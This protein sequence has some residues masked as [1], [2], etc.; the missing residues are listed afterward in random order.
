MPVRRPPKRSDELCRRPQVR[1][2][3]LDVFAQVQEGFTDQNERSDG[4]MD[5]WDLYDCKLTDKQFYNGQSQIFLPYVR[6]AVNARKTRFCN[7]IFPQSGR[8]VDVFT[9]DEYLPDATIALLETYVRRSR[10]KTEVMPAL[11]KNGDIEGQY[12]VYVS[13]VEERRQVTRREMT[14]SVTVGEIELPELG[15]HAE[16][17][18]TTEVLGRPQVDVIHDADFLVL[19]VTANSIRDA[20]AQGGSVTVIRRWTKGRIESAI[21][22]G[23]IDE[24]QG[25]QLLAAMQKAAR[26]GNRNTGARLA[27]A[28]G[29]RENGEFALIYET[30]TN[31]RVDGRSYLCVGLYGGDSNVL[32]CKRCPYWCDLPPIISAPVEK[33]ADV[34]KG[35]AP[36]DAVATLQVFAN[37]TINE[38]ADTAHFSAMPIVMTDPEKN[39]KTS[40]M[41]LGLAA[42]WETSPQDTQFAQFPE[43]WVSAMQRAQ[44]IQGQIFQ[45]LGVNPS[46]M[47]QSSGGE[48]KR[49]QAEIANEQQVDILTTADAV[50]VLEEGILTPLIQR[51][52]E[53]DHQFR[54][55]KAVVATY[56]PMGYRATM[57]EVE[58]IQLNKRFE[59]VWLGVEAARNAAQLQQQIAGMNVLK[60]I[61]PQMYPGYRLNLQP[62][63]ENM[64]LSMFG[65]RL[66][67][68]VFERV[69]DVTVDPAIENQMLANAFIVETHPPDDDEAHL[70]EHM[71]AL[72]A[73]G[74]V[75]AHGTFRDHIAKHQ[76]QMQM[77]A[78]AQAMSMA[79]EQQGMPGS[80]GA[81]GMPGA[82]GTPRPGG[83]V[84]GPRLMKGPAGMIHPD[85]MTAAGAV[86]MPRNM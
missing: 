55:D 36:V 28:A 80:P 34:F 14:P 24:E 77:K 35:K 44:A 38:G 45:T 17:R 8:Y 67:P 62:A 26:D 33:Q 50:G 20:L 61:P 21:D 40:T 5:N 84:D 68:L 60:G 53:Y 56:G 4:I 85:E 27:D 30:W 86:P 39:P 47:P 65:P 23:E 66:A 16:F 78:Q 48:N 37:D 58:P 49:N 51:F 22:N 43:L 6:D 75:D 42:V 57:E 73:M 11:L 83:Q 59:F 9:G 19:P 74:G 31:V 1:K 63:I 10:L 71:A 69:R 41:V 13:W 15:E 12:T 3:L 2:Q 46:M 32:S 25:K 81:M 70:M 64:V 82:A 52:V 54:E 7:Q 79:P 72:E 29:I 76:Q 18:E